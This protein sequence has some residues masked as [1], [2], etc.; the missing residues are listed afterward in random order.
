MLCK[1]TESIETRIEIESKRI[2]YRPIAAYG[3]KLIA[4]IFGMNRLLIYYQFSL[5]DL[6]RLFEKVHIS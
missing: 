3:A 4:R 1:R 2:E 6:L 5:F